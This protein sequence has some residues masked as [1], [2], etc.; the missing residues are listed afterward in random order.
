M[1]HGTH[2]MWLR[3]GSVNHRTL[4]SI[5]LLFSVGLWVAAP[6]QTSVIVYGFLLISFV[7]GCS[8]ASS[9]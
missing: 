3:L 6:T 4:G 1:T 2:T 8:L 7:A 9:P 5:L